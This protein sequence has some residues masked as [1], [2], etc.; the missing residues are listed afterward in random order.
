MRFVVVAGLAACQLD[1]CRLREWALVEQHPEAVDER[2]SR[3]MRNVRRSGSDAELRLR[4]ELHR[5]GLRYQVD[6]R[7]LP[8]SPDVAFTRAKIA[9]FVDGCFWHRCPVHGSQPKTNE[10]WWRR[11]LD[12]N[13]ERDRRKDAELEGLGWLP[14]HVWEHEDPA[15]AASLIY[16]L[17]LTRRDSESW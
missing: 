3:R 12:A 14:V 5:S 1:E 2:T 6:F 4:R 13:V 7:G 15:E 16:E 17:W 9:V 11:K 8:G 10:I